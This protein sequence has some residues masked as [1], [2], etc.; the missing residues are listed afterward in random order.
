M[1]LLWIENALPLNTRSERMLGSVHRSGLFETTVCA[2]NR[3]G[4]ACPEQSDPGFRVFSTSTGDKRLVRKAIALPAFMSFV[5][6]TVR[7]ERPDVIVASFWDSALAAAW[8]SLGH[9]AP[10]V[11]DALDMPG[12]GR[13][14]YTTG[15][16]LER[17]ALSRVTAT[18]LASRFYEPFYRATGRPHLILENLPDLGA[19]PDLSAHESQ[20][21]RVAY[22]GSLRF[23]ETLEPLIDESIALGLHLDLFGGGPD[24]PALQ[25]HARGESIIRFHGP[26]EYGDLPGIYRQVD[27]LW[28]A[29]PAYDIN[30]RY[31]I[32]NKYFE[33]LWFGVPA[34][35]SEGTS[36]G[37]M[38]A[39]EG[40]GFVVDSTARG[41]VRS[42]LQRLHADPESLAK[43]RQR[44]LE[45]RRNLEGQLSWE[46][47]ERGF[48]DFLR[49]ICNR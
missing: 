43:T 16:L 42:L 12:G 8:A 5:A 25:L 31:A 40:T 47:Q 17:T 21:P 46:S 11:Y 45:K 13:L 26:Y 14:L 22:V 27:L 6:R 32:S 49:A 39:S 1:R 4:K 9:R 35:F 15:R 18:V 48:V 2:W 19:T 20:P 7:A 38:V 28:A 33:S 44:L 37:E 10:I 29:Y 36:L 23:P 24:L 34:V 3:S 41:A 30:V